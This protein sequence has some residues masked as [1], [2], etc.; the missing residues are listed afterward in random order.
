MPHSVD[1]Q[2]SWLNP[3]GACS[4]LAEVRTL[5]QHRDFN[6]RRRRDDLTTQKHRSQSDEEDLLQAKR[7]LPG[8]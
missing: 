5:S 2:H 4:L 1:N 7:S 3:D 6:A 8:P